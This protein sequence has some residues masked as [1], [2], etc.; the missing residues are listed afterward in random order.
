MDLKQITSGQY[1]EMT[2]EEQLKVMT[3]IYRELFFR[4]VKDYGLE[5]INV[6][7]DY[8]INDYV[9]GNARIEIAFGMLNAA[10]GMLYQTFTNQ[11]RAELQS[12]SEGTEFAARISTELFDLI[13]QMQEDTHTAIGLQTWYHAALAHRRESKRHLVDADGTTVPFTEHEIEQ[14]RKAKEEHHLQWKEELEAQRQE[15]E[16]GYWGKRELPELPEGYGSAQ[17]V[18]PLWSAGFRPE[19]EN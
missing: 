4:N 15:M 5:F 17:L 1:L 10:I 12:L 3:E 19:E 9:N 14:G 8:G 7:E 18:M 2:E 13:N 6:A 11:N 16:D